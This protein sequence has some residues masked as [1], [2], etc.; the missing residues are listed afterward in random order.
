MKNH[1]NNFLSDTS[2][3]YT[4]SS[5]SSS[6]GKTNKLSNRKLDTYETQ[7]NYFDSLNSDSEW[8]IYD[9]STNTATLSSVE[10]F[11][12]HYKSESKDVGAFDDLSKTQEENKLFSIDGTTYTKHFDKIMA[13]LMLMINY[14]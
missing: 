12:T 3:P 10:D 13:Q 4:P 11:V 8:I 2:F 9:S 6:R 1:L 14:K 7:S 5:S